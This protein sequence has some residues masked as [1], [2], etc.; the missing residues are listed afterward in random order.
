MSKLDAIT[1]GV[2]RD[3][4][5]NNPL[6]QKTELGRPLRRCFTLPPDGF[7]YGK[8][9]GNKDSGAADALVWR[10]APPQ[11]FSHKEKKK[12][13]DFQSLN[14][15]AV[16][17][18]L[19]TAQEHFQYRATHDVRRKDSGN[20]RTTQKIKRLPPTMVFGVPTKPSTPVYDLL[21]HKYQDRWLEERRKAEDGMR[22]RQKQKRHV[23]KNIYETRA[24]LLR[25]YQPPVDP[26]PLWHMAKF[27]KIP[28]VTVTFR[29][30]KAKSAA[31]DHHATDSTSRKGVFGHGIY[32]PAKS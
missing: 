4:L 12:P 27:N 31:F 10:S 16:Q 8:P 6:L 20:E 11:Q 25:K 19:T 15:S 29:S 23:D 21:G 18:G 5:L 14:K 22:A 17:V 24:S 30:E 32:E 1:L 9:N 13:R 7:T 28:P 26:P 3:S 2:H